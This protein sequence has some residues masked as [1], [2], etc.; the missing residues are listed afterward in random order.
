MNIDDFKKICVVGWAKTGTSLCNLLLA[1]QKDI[2]VSE[3]KEAGSFDQAQVNQ[4][5][6]KGV[7]FEFGGHSKDFIKGA[8]LLILSPGV[9][10]VKSEAIKIAKEEGIPY[11]GEIEFCFWLTQAKFIAITGT[12]GKTTTTHLTY[13]VLK[14]KRKRVFLGGNIGIPLSS[15]VLDAKK[16]DLIVLEVSSFQLETILKFK[17][18]VGALLNIEPDH[19]DRYRNLE[20]YLQAK[21]NLF[22][23]QESRDWAIINKD[24]NFR[25][26]LNEKIRSKIIYFGDEFE[27]ENLSCVYRIASIF[28]LSRTDCLNVFSCFKGLPHRLQLVKTIKGVNFI[29]DSKATNPSSTIWALKN[30][31][32]PIILLAGGKDKGLEYSSIMPYTKRVKKINFFGEAALKIKNSLNCD[33]ACDVFSSL[34]DATIASFKEAQSGDTVLLS[35]MCASFDEFSNYQE[36]GEKFSEIVNNL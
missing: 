22:R 25:S 23:N 36:R 20:E 33:I 27:N 14:E 17:P 34:K 19:L 16:G 31:K 26:Y 9:D 30:T 28:G 13:Q 21:M 24:F 4:F 2:R 7:N 15:F 1:L 18:Y 8:Q 5:L 32:T 6:D 12:N 35:P 29:N 10:T 11:V 3:S